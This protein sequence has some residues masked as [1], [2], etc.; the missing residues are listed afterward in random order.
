MVLSSN[1]V[2]IIEFQEAFSLFDNQND[3]KIAAS[4]VGV[5]LRSLGQNPTE[6]D[7][8]KCCNE[9]KPE[10]RITFDEFLPILQTVSKC[11][12]NNTA[13]DYVD[14]LRNHDAD[15]SGVINATVFRRL[16]THL[17]EPL[18]EDEVEQLLVGHEDEEGNVQYEEL[19]KTV[20]SG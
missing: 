17:G 6:A 18:T 2:I 19:V 15:G 9:L 5:V 20:L 16:M 4:Q 11:K 1:T 13:D 14:G 3:G 10:D 12:S 7:V 8:Q